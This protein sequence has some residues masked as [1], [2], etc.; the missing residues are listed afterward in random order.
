M[1]KYW[2][3]Q[4][5]LCIGKGPE[6]LTN[7]WDLHNDNAPANKAP[8]IKQLLAKKSITELEHPPCYPDLASNDFWLFSK[9]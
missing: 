7:D 1:W 5:R 3:G 2:S 9:I 6:F 4:L 8:S